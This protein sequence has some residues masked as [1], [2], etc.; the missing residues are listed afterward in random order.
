M[1]KETKVKSNTYKKLYK[2]KETYKKKAKNFM[3][4]NTKLE[5]EVGMLKEKLEE[6]HQVADMPE[7][8]VEKQVALYKE[9][10]QVFQKKLK[11][12]TLWIKHVADFVVESDSGS[13]SE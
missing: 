13:D 7:E 2:K 4:E 6:E 12:F 3:K 10:K 5:E 8:D 11:V 9:L 1:P